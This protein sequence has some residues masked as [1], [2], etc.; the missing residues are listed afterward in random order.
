[1]GRSNRRGVRVAR[2]NRDRIGT[3]RG[4]LRATGEVWVLGGRA[5]VASRCTGG[6]LDPR[7]FSGLSRWRYGSASCRRLHVGRVRAT[8]WR[9]RS[10]TGVGRR[11]CRD[12]TRIFLIVRTEGNLKVSGSSVPGTS[13]GCERARTERRERGKGT[14]GGRCCWKRKPAVAVL[15]LRTRA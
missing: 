2:W 13:H 6:L 1:M 8:T 4:G 7:S 3:R 14:G 5:T 10:H 9:W 11:C 12:T 15:E